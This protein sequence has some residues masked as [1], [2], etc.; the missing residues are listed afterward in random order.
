MSPLD[1]LHPKIP[2]LLPSQISFGAQV[3][4]F[5]WMIW[6][7]LATMAAEARLGQDPAHRQ[8]EQDSHRGDQA[9]A[10]AEDIFSS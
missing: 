7:T 9:N 10:A 3:R 8:R 2:R 1:K 5:K 4:Q 6:R